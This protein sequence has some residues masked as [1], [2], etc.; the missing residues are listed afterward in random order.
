M[1]RR[2]RRYGVLL[3]TIALLLASACSSGN[4]QHGGKEAPLETK[5]KA[6]VEAAARSQADAIAALAGGPL[7]AWRTSTTACEGRN[8]EIAEDG[9]WDLAGFAHVKL[10]GD[11]HAAALRA[12]HDKWQAEGWEISAYQTQAD[13]GVLSGRDPHTGLSFTLASSKPPI[14]IAVTVASPCYQ[15]AEGEDPANG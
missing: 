5:R 15:P 8:G 6:D 4:D 1:T 9:R 11:K 3:A 13:G 2:G 7:E 14:Q 12:V 10:P